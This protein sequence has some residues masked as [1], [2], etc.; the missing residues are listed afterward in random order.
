M[1]HMGT[2]E[3]P[4]PGAEPSEGGIPPSMLQPE[5]EQRKKGKFRVRFPD[6]TTSEFDDPM[7]AAAEMT[8]WREN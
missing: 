3:I 4:Q 5:G 7:E 1:N 2:R 6:G 8:K